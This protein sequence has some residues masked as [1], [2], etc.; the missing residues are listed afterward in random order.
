MN[1]YA[2]A[3]GG[4]YRR[5]YSRVSKQR[6]PCGSIVALVL[7]RSIL[8]ILVFCADVFCCCHS[9]PFRMIILFRFRSVFDAYFLSV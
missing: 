3:A 1:I 6:A 5:H 4:A 2:Q 8:V 9:R 7:V